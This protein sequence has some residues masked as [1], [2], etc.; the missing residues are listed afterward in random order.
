MTDAGDVEDAVRELLRS[1]GEDPDDE[2]L[3]ET[4]ARVA[5]MYAELFSGLD[6]EPL[7]L[8]RECPSG[9]AAGLLFAKLYQ[10]TREPR[11][12]HAAERVA[13]FMATRCTPK[14]W[15]DYECHFDS[16]GKPFDLVDHHSQQR[17]Q[18]TF[19]MY[20]AAELAKTLFHITGEDR[21]R[22][23]DW[24]DMQDEIRASWDSRYPGQGFDDALEDILRGWGDGL[25]GPDPDLMENP[26]P[27]E[28][29]GRF[30]QG[31]QVTLGLTD[32]GLDEDED[33]GLDDLTGD[34]PMGD[35]GDTV[36][37]VSS[38]EMA[39]K[40]DMHYVMDMDDISDL[41]TAEDE[42]NRGEDVAH[43]D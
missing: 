10:S 25:V 23:R 7:D 21:Y 29:A 18:C 17:P 4:P 33:I 14:G 11:F 5:R 41:P 31:A 28:M 20:W 16:A 35:L 42:G 9:A 6:T 27:A 26:T 22:E 43:L 19:P 2:R 1:V 12:L 8:L 37:I 24:D 36:R 30:D 38:E 3:K 13:A 40:I 34:S 15:T 39:G 32:L